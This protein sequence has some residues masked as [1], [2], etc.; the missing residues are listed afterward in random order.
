LAG[1]IVINELRLAGVLGRRRAG[2]EGNGLDDAL[3]GRGRITWADVERAPVL[4]QPRLVMELI[5]GKLTD[6]GRLPP[7]GAF[8]ARELVRAADLNVAEAR[9]RLSE[10]ALTAER[11]RYAADGVSPAMAETVVTHARELL[12]RLDSREMAAPSARG[13]APGDEGRQ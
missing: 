6:L 13:A 2:R 9:E 3:G 10:V 11:A 12:A 8:T 4:D 1:L 7:A 5:A